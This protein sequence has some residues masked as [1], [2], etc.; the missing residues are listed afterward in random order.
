MVQVVDRAQKDPEY[1]DAIS[2]IF[3]L[4]EKWINKVCFTEQC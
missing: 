2:T 1:R 4:V 3:D